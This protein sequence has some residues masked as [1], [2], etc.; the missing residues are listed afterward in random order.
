MKNKKGKCSE[1]LHNSK[2]Q[3]E[4]L[5][6]AYTSQATQWVRSGFKKIN[7]FRLLLSKYAA[8]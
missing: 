4:S 5:I 8:D 1:D 3:K 7:K 2:G 6:L